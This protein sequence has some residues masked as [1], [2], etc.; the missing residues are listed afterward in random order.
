MST[1]RLIC[2]VFGIL[3]GAAV[4]VNGFR[5]GLAYDTPYDVGRVIAY[6]FGWI[7]IGAGI[8]GLRPNGR[9]PRQRELDLY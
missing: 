5:H 2:A 4:V 9:N 8:A 7:L 6:L 1:R 3:W